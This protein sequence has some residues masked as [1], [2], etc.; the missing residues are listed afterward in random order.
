MPHYPGS[1]SVYPSSQSRLSTLCRLEPV[2]SQRNPCVSGTPRR[3]YRRAR[4]QRQF[5]R[6]PS[7]S[8]QNRHCNGSGTTIKVIIKVV[9]QFAHVKRTHIRK[10]RIPP[11]ITIPLP[12]RSTCTRRLLPRRLKAHSSSS[13]RNLEPPRNCLATR[14]NDFL[15]GAA[16]LRRTS[17]S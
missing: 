9:Y 8:C 7:D 4:F 6:K 16:Y 14:K 10:Q 5:P 1:P 15:P 13:L 3:G 11:R 12:A 17:Y 2:S